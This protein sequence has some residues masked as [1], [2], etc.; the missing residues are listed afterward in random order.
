MIVGLF[1]RNYKCYKGAKFIPF[2][3]NKPNNL[4]VFIGNNGA[5]KS[6]ILEALDT[7]FNDREW[8][9]HTDA[10]KVDVNVGVLF[11]SSKDKT[12]ERLGKN[13]YKL[14]ET[15]SDAFWNVQISSNSNYSRYGDFFDLRE[16]LK[17][18]K[19]THLLFVLGKNYSDKNVSFLTFQSYII[20]ELSLNNQDFNPE[21]LSPL[22]KMRDEFASYYTFLYIPVETA[23]SEFLR[24]ETKGMQNLMNQ[25][26]KE[27]ISGILNSRTIPKS[28]NSDHSKT[29]I[30]D[31]INDS[32]ETFIE[33]VERTI[34]NIDSDYNFKKE[35]KSKQNLTA[36]HVTDVIIEAYFSKR[37][38]R[39]NSKSITNLSA[40]ERKRALIDIAYSF[41]S[42]SQDQ[43]TE[44]ILAIDEPESSLHISL[45]YEQF[46]RVEQIA[47]NF[48]KQVFITTHWYGALPILRNGVLHHVEFTDETPQVKL[49]EL[50]NYFEKRKSH[51]DDIQM[52]SFFDLASSIVSS[53]RNSEKN[54]LLVEGTEDKLYLDYYLEDPKIRVLP[55]G[56]ASIVKIIY[57]YIYLPLSQKS[58]SK[59][60]N[61]KIFCLIDTDTSSIQLNVDSETKNKLLE[62]RRLQYNTEEDT[63][64]LLRVDSNYK[65]ETEIENCLVPEHFYNALKNAILM[66]NSSELKTAFSYFDFDSTVNVSFVRNDYSI[67]NH[68]GEGRNIRQDK[69]IITDFIDENKD[70][71]AK[72]YI[73]LPKTAEPNWIQEIREFFSE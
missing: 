65:S 33:N 64:K 7:F 73:K 57:E 45:C 10:N 37:R 29:S 71:V 28:N 50:E 60:H 70:L 38:L 68:R 6:S 20:D 67:L 25:D 39:K 36:N 72:E 43:D 2:V 54:W 3:V 55:L 40:G 66:S 8:T 17:I 24:L 21:N 35:Y 48:N 16:K 30:L 19:D 27:K 11:L 69:R 53:L 44:I 32:L 18:Y 15:I 5:G 59:H 49:F 4:K 31:Y 1:I 13:S 12:K 52:K 14:L 63:I 62:I 47:Q 56:G 23:I 42:Q 61:G 41:L 22:N 9:V 26:I 58:E 46:Y 51:P 34:Q